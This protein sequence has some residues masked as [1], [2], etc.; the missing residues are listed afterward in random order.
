MTVREARIILTPPLKFGNETQ[1]KASKL[2]AI[3]EAALKMVRDGVEDTC[4]ECCGEGKIK[5]SACDGFGERLI[6]ESEMDTMTLKELE[7]IL[8]AEE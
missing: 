2:I 3:Y 6:K 8:E 7:D 4:P 5:C 1:I